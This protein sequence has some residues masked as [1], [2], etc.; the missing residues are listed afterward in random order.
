MLLSGEQLTKTYG[1]RTLLDGV[2][3]YVD[4]GDKV[5]VI[6]VN[7]TGKST[8]LRL[9]AGAEEPDE[10][11]VRPDPN[12]RLEYLPQNPEFAPGTTVLEQ[13]LLW[14]QALEKAVVPDYLYLEIKMLY[15][16]FLQVKPV[17]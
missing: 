17:A 11:T 13:V 5:G 8:L 10:G 16:F 6:G 14:Q 1:T 9:L 4:R 3:F 7:G 15:Y 2:S 12:V